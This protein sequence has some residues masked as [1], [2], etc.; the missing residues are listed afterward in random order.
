M[1]KYKPEPADA[2]DKVD[3][4]H[5]SRCLETANNL[6]TGD[7]N[8]QYGSPIADFSA[9]AGMWTEYLAE[10]LLPGVKLEPHDVAAMMVLLKVSRLRVSPGKED[11]WVDIA[12]YA[13]CGME[14]AILEG[15]GDDR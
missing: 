10:R 8:R 4:T 2:D 11:H 12:G 5:R 7:R 14:C 6:I 15:E 3:F 1:P 13:G 9:T